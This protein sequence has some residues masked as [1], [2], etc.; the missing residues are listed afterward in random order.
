MDNPPAINETRFGPQEAMSPEHEIEQPFEEMEARRRKA[1]HAVLS[2]VAAFLILV[3]L[4]VN[5]AYLWITK[6][7]TEPEETAPIVPA[8]E[9]FDV[10]TS[11]HQLQI[12]A[13]GVVESVR[14]VAVS[15]EVGGRVE[16][17]SP[18]DL[19]VRDWQ[20]SR[21]ADYGLSPLEMAFDV[22]GW[23]VCRRTDIRTG[24]LD[25]SLLHFVRET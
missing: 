21:V 24:G 7:K 17:V 8:V 23:R 20:L 2:F 11:N 10:T 22:L 9:V 25:R 16:F 1:T 13:Q 5:V 6:Q 18:N 19:H 15:A 4:V 14:E 12:V 3:I